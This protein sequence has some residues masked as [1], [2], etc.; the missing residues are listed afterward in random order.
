MQM[1]QTIVGPGH[2]NNYK[3]MDQSLSCNDNQDKGASPIFCDTQNMQH[4]SWVG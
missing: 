1:E 2:L 3:R 4:I